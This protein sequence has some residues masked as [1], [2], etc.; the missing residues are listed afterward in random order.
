M[1]NG[2]L[3]KDVGSDKLMIRYEFKIVDNRIVF[4]DKKLKIIYEDSDLDMFFLDNDFCLYRCHNNVW[5]LVD[6]NR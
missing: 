3:F 4:D 1:R 2:I 6:L 5:I